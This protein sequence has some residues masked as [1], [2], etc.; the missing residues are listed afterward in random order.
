MLRAALRKLL[1][2]TASITETLRYELNIAVERYYQATGGPEAND[3]LI[4]LLIA[5]TRMA[6]HLEGG[7]GLPMSDSACMCSAEEGTARP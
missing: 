6:A 7:A 3:A 4:G 5:S 1:P 2:R